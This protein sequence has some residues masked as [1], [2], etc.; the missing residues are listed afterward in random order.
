MKR[1]KDS[2]KRLSKSG[3]SYPSSKKRNN[4]KQFVLNIASNSS[5]FILNI[6]IGIWLVPYLIT[7]LGVDVYGIIPLAVS[8]S[9]YMGLITVPFSLSITRFLGIDLKRD[10]VV[11]NQTFNTA[12]FGVLGITALVFPFVTLAALF[13]PDIVNIPSGHEDPVRLLFFLLFSSVL[14][15][16][17]C[18][19][20]FVSIFSQNRLELSSLIQ[21]VGLVIRILFI[22]ILFFFL[23]PQ[24][25]HV[26][27]GFLG[28]TLL[29]LGGAVWSWRYLTPELIIRCSSFNRSRLNDLFG[30]TGWVFVNQFG[31]LL[32]LN[33]DLIVV[34][35]LFGTESGGKYGA[36]LQ[37]VILLRS[38]SGMLSGVLSPTILAFYAEGK[39][40]QLVNFIKLSIKYLGL[41]MAIPIGLICG[42]ADPLLTIWLG[43]EYA[44]LEPL[45]WLL[46]AHL[47]IN[48]SVRPMFYVQQAFN[49]V[50]IPGLVTLVMGCANLLLALI[51]A[52]VFDWGIYGVAAAGAIVL[53]IKNTIFT[54]LYGSKI[55][56]VSLTAFIWPMLPGVAG[57]IMLAGGSFLVATE[58]G[59]VDWISFIFYSGLLSFVYLIFI[60][61]NFVK[62][63]ERKLIFSL[64][65]RKI[66]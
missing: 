29:V 21:G 32:F 39:I 58:V 52:I 14:V 4:K 47:C 37:W 54:P 1:P 25:W 27:V 40:D 13:V 44:G 51:L 66:A 30:M 10:I 35:R 64:L 3:P 45:M 9:A 28:G 41:V 62:K 61:F 22:V 43:P 5:Y 36:V 55:L 50:K 59:V 63:D 6:V 49:K 60:Y 56:N 31:S 11:A 34:N 19:C 16:F 53:T 8:I 12:Y 24:L 7:H 26:G 33:I 65:H 18:S 48:V 17:I 46:V 38:L 2:E 20:F 42:F 15:T 23:S 57:T